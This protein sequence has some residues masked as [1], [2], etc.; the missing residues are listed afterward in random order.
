VSSGL[1]YQVVVDPNGVQNVT[2]YVDTARFFADSVFGDPEVV[3]TAN[4]DA[5]NNTNPLLILNVSKKARV[6]VWIPGAPLTA[7]SFIRQ[8]ECPL[9]A[10]NLG[11]WSFTGK[12]INVLDT[13]NPN[14]FD[15]PDTYDQ[16]FNPGQVVLGPR[17]V[18]SPP[19]NASPQMYFVSVAPCGFSTVTCP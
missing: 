6:T 1:P 4:T 8:T 9:G 2:I 3:V 13:S 11:C 10:P 15:V 5:F 14:F 12:G 19:N 7:N 17:A 18:D 16:T